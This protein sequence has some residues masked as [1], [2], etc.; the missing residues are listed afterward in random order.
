MVLVYL[1][2]LLEAVLLAAQCLLPRQLLGDLP[3]HGDGVVDHALPL[4]HCLLPG[5]VVLVGTVLL[6]LSGKRQQVEKQLE[7]ENR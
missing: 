5:L 6:T 1:H 2:A 7:E 4:R 3:H